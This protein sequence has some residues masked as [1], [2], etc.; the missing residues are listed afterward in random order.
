M[1]IGIYSGSY[2]PIHS[3]HAMLASYILRNSD[4]DEL[5]LVVTPQNPLKQDVE[6][7][8]NE[9]RLAMAKLVA[10]EID[11]LYASD[12]EFSLPQPSYTYTTLCKLNER[13]PMHQFVLIVGSDNW[14]IF[15]KWRDN[16]KIISEY[17][18]LI[19]PRP[20]FEIESEILPDNVEFLSAAPQIEVSSTD[21]RRMLQEGIDVSKHLPIRV[22]DYIKKENLYR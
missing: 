21:V 1:K 5:W 18:L 9:H 6:M 13:F 2:N 10:G 12:F 19:Y 4:L 14:L 7:A 16:E 20:G 8:A 22:Y 11:G 15:N 3:G 17:G